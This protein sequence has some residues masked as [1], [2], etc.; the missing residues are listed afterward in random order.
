M[1]SIFLLIGFDTYLD[2]IDGG[3][4]L[5]VICHIVLGI[6]LLALYLPCIYILV[7]LE[8][9]TL[10]F[11]KIDFRGHRVDFSRLA[12]SIENPSSKYIVIILVYVPMMLPI[13]VVLLPFCLYNCICN[14]D[15][16]LFYY[17]VN[18]S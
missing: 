16:T 13:S 17:A 15:Y 5:K 10:L 11:G 1:L 2:G 14:N 18:R 8:V 4:C 9:I 3:C 7:L 6:P 12:D